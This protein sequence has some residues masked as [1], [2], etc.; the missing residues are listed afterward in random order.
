MS[1]DKKELRARLNEKQWELFNDIK[2]HYGFES[3]ADLIR[4]IIKD[5]WEQIQK[6]QQTVEF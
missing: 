2:Q 1:D 5:K 6:E 3:N 4:L